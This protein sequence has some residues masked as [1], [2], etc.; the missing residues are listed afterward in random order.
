[1]KKRALLLTIIIAILFSLI[2]FSY[3]H[4]VRK[5]N[6]IV[7]KT[8][9]KLEDSNDFYKISI[10]YPNEKRDNEKVIQKYAEYKFNEK[11]DLWRVDG[12]DY[13]QRKEMLKNFPDSANFLFEY[14]SDF[15]IV[16]SK[17]LNTT[18]YIFKN[19]EYTGGANGITTISTF[20]FS[21]DGKMEI[22]NILNLKDDNNDIKLTKIMAK[23]L[24]ENEKIKDY[25]EKEMIFQGLGLNC[26]DGENNFNKEACGSEAF[27]FGSNFQNFIIKDDGLV[28]IMNKYQVAAGAAGNPEVYFSWEE[29]K[30]FLLL[31]I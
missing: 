10:S 26:V 31:N 15:E 29:L 28:F 16:N 11:K 27:F 18:S 22:E 7:N 17:K 25:T 2:Y 1:M 8:E 23:K 19:Y 14:I 9:T 6:L 30:P 24:S 12:E 3:N 5:D 13:N 4:F 21:E 20:S